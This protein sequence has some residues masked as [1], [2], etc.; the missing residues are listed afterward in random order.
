M[1]RLL[2]LSPIYFLITLLWN[3]N[4]CVLMVGVNLSIELL[5]FFLKH[6]NKQK[7]KQKQK[8]TDG[9]T[10]LRSYI[11]FLNLQ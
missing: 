11:P 9:D 3:R 5:L 7:Q 1:P 6:K 8:K 4:S 2:N 10:G